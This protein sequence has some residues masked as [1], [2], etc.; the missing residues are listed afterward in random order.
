[1]RPDSVLN[2]SADESFVGQRKSLVT[3]AT[4]VCRIAEYVMTTGY[5]RFSEDFRL[6]LKVSGSVPK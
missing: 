1:M 6:A 2:T 5:I 3:S 4:P